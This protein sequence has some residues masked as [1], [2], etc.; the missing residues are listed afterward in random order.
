MG[1]GQHGSCRHRCAAQARRPV[2]DRGAG[3]A[4]GGGHRPPGGAVHRVL[5]LHHRPHP[6]G[7]GVRRGVELPQPRPG[8]QAPGGLRVQGRAGH[9]RR[10]VGAGRAGQHAP[11]AGRPLMG[12]P[13]DAGKTIA[14]AS[15][16]AITAA[17]CV[18]P[19]AWPIAAEAYKIQ[20]DPG[21]IYQAGLAWL[22]SAGKLGQALDAAMTINNSIGGSGWEGKDYDAF[23]GKAAD[24]V[25]Q[26]MVARIFAY[27]VGIA[28]I[29]AAV[30]TFLAILV[31][32]VMAVG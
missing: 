10:A 1:R 17:A 19:D 29:V 27:T 31:F 23:T 15:L 20:S 28:L 25:R 13:L 11:A 32:A 30:E 6:A 26:L 12:T 22:D 4:R 14:E 8:D 16:I 24:Y 7:G 9:H 18:I 3:A 2:R 5:Q 21:G